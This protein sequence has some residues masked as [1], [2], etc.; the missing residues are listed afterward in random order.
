[1]GDKAGVKRFDGLRT[2]DLYWTGS[3]SAMTESHP[4]PIRELTNNQSLRNVLS[5]TPDG[6]GPRIVSTEEW[7]VKRAAL[8]ET[9][10]RYLGHPDNLQP[11]GTEVETLEAFPERD[12]VRYLIRYEAEADDPV[13]A[14]LCIPPDDRRKGGAAIVCQH[15][16]SDVAKDGEIGLAQKPGRNFARF[17]ATRG[18][19]TLAPDHFCAGQRQPEGVRPYETAPFQARHPNWSAVGKTIHDGRRAVDVLSARP[20]VDPV[21]IGTIGHSLGGYGSFFLGAFEER[22]RA[23]VCSCGMT[24]WQGNPR[25]AANWAR[26]HWYCHFPLLREVF[27]NNEPLPFDF[28]E[29]P[30]LMAPRAFLNLSGLSDQMYG[31]NQTLGEIGLQLHALW[32]LLGHGEAFANFLFGSGHDVPPYNR[33]L[34]AA[35]FDRWLC[36]DPP[37]L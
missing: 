34:I 37:I 12:F 19:V 6:R 20:E 23:A 26:D 25:A 8:K 31:N 29:I 17:L 36:D 2:E 4:P 9:I 18:Y 30:A 27:L 14:W 5:R 10:E 11:P 3:H 13:T 21:R 16:T 35:W 32:E 33:A 28:H 24:S 1:M 15:G 22:I 7:G